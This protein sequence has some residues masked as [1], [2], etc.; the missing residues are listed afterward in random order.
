MLLVCKKTV[1]VCLSEPVA[2]DELVQLN[3]VL[4]ERH[5][6]LKD[7]SSLVATRHCMTIGLRN[8]C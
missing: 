8:S 5:V 2:P 3:V 4:Q 6:V 7:L 1:E